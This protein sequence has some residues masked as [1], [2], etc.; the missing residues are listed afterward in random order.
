M[1]MSIHEKDAVSSAVEEITPRVINHPHQDLKAHKRPWWSL[2]GDDRSFA[3]SRPE[4]LTE[5][6]TS[7][8]EDIETNVIKDIDQSVF[9]DTQAARYYQPIENYEGRHRFDPNAIWSDEEE[10]KLV[11]RVSPSLQCT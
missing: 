7:S 4:A 9:S 11:R 3:T 2:G 1:A 5:S 10:K 6:L 8:K